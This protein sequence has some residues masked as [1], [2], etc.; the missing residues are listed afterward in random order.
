MDDHTFLKEAILQAL[1]STS[2]DG[3]SV[4]AVIVI[5]GRII[6]KAFSG[7]SKENTHAEEHAIKR[8]TGSLSGATIYSTMEPCDTRRSGKRSCCDLIIE[9]KIA[10]VVFGTFD[11]DKRIVCNGAETLETA[12]INAYQ[13]KELEEECKKL[14]P[15]LF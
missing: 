11:P 4:G 15:R 9:N 8:Y 12:G 3:Y 13:L 1:K 7:E 2:E 6:S 10:R 5:E 14:C